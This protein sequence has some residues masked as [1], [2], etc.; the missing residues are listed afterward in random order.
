MFED[1]FTKD[2]LV[3]ELMMK[4]FVEQPRL[5]GVCQLFLVLI[6]EKEEEKYEKYCI[7][8]TLNFLMC[9]DKS[10]DLKNPKKL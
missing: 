5:H 6:S 2:D 7:W 9:A 1:I 4:L 10:T 8:E 3:T